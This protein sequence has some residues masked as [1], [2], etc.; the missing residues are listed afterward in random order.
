MEVVPGAEPLY[1]SNT[2]QCR[3]LHLALVDVD[4]VD[5]SFHA[6]FSARGKRYCYRV[7][8]GDVR[9]PLRS[10]RTHAVARSLDLGQMT[11]AAKALVGRH[12]FSSFQAAGTPV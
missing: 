8:N 6:R 2:L 9:S 12:D 7:W 4:G 1:N 5:D 11:L 10:R 3:E